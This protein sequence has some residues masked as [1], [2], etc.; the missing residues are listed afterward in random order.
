MAAV[1]TVLLRCVFR[2]GDFDAE[3]GFTVRLAN[4]DIFSATAPSAYFRTSLKGEMEIYPLPES[5]EV[6]GFVFATIEWSGWRNGDVATVR[7][8]TGIGD[9]SEPIEVPIADVAA[10]VRPKKVVEFVPIED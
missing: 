9:D 3:A 10:E 5:G 2:R 6:Q 8:P 7:V 1:R 4:G